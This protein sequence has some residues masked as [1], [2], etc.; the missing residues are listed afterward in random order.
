MRIKNFLILI[1]LS[2][3]VFL[4]SCG[5]KVYTKA[6]LPFQEIYLRNVENHTVEPG[7]QD[8]MRKIL[9]QTLMDNGFILT[10]SANRALDIQIKNYRLVGLSEVGLN[11][12]EY[13]VLLDVKAVLYDEKG[14]KIKEFNPV[15]AFTTFFRTTRD[16]QSIIANREVAI[17]SLM[18]DI[19]DDIVRK[20]IFEKDK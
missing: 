19:C 7:I 3:G 10:S 9:Y 8:K 11:I 16:L 12:L 1:L 2:A 6:N 4:Y 5:Y 13:Q 18:R 20:I 15:S 17:D 14:Q